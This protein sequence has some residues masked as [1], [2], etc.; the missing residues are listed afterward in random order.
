MMGE[1]IGKQLE[2]VIRVYKDKDGRCKDNFV[3][4]RANIDVMV[5]LRKGFHVQLGSKSAKTWI[6]VKYER[7]GDFCF[8]C[9]CLGHSWK[10]YPGK[11]QSRPENSNNEMKTEHTFGLW[12]RAD[13]PNCFVSS[14]FQIWGTEAKEAR[15]R[16]NSSGKTRSKAGSS[17]K[18]R[19]PTVSPWEE[20]RHNHSKGGSRNLGNQ[21]KV[22]ACDPFS[23]NGRSFNH[24]ASKT[25][26]LGNTD[27]PNSLP[28]I[29]TFY[30]GGW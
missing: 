28:G 26:A 22:G 19:S 2:T 21:E 9:G 30:W 24:D 6:D 18:R 7:L 3:R 25:Q 1:L 14:S 29:G 20:N 10:F 11:Q 13:A 8:D 15:D 17:A 12:L 23:A 5:H 4:I 16:L 27:N